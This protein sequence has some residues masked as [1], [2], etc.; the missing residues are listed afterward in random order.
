MLINIEFNIYFLKIKNPEITGIDSFYTIFFIPFLQTLTYKMASL[1]RVPLLLWIL[2]L[3]G[4]QVNANPVANDAIENESSWLTQWKKCFFND[5]SEDVGHFFL[6]RLINCWLTTTTAIT[7]TTT[8]T[9]TTAITSTGDIA[10]TYC[11]DKLLA[12]FQL[13]CQNVRRKRSLVGLQDVCCR[14]R[15]T[16]QEMSL[17]C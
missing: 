14:R 8:N 6:T 7:P 15:C 12:I 13:V 4:I 9:S 10:G 5:A 16:I 2:V 1:Q 11:G 17:F 3:I